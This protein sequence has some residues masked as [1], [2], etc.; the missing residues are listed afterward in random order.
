MLAYRPPGP[1]CGPLLDTNTTASVVP[2]ATEGSL[3]LKHVADETWQEPSPQG[4]P[5]PCPIASHQ[6]SPVSA[7]RS[8]QLQKLW[9]SGKQTRKFTGSGVQILLFQFWPNSPEQSLRRSAAK[10]IWWVI[11]RLWFVLSPDG[12]SHVAE[13]L[14]SGRIKKL[15]LWSPMRRNYQRS[16]SAPCRGDFFFF[17]LQQL[18]LFWSIERALRRMGSLSVEVF[19]PKEDS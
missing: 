13:G 17:F 16:I 1:L 4:S 14:W 11:S 8:N 12:C 15:A 7:H 9:V 19:R 5:S 3:S 10:L 6:Q 2:W 18:S